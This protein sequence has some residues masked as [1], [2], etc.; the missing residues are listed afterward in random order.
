MLHLVHPHVRT[1]RTRP[2][3]FWR[4]ITRVFFG[5]LAFSVSVSHAVNCVSNFVPSNPDSAYQVDV[6]TGV[7]TDSRTG[8]MWKRAEESTF[9]NWP[10][11]LATAEAS[12]YAGY[13]DW[14]LPNIKELRS[15]V[16]ECRVQ[17]AIN[18]TIFP[19]GST[20]GV[21]SASPNIDQPNRAW[22]VDIRY[23]VDVSGLRD[24]QAYAV[25]LVRGGGAGFFDVTSPVLSAVSA[26]LTALTATSNEAATGY[27]I[28]VARGATAPTAAQ[29]KARVTYAG[30][31]I[32][33][34]GSGAMGAN[35][36]SSFPVAALSVNTLYDFY[37]VADDAAGNISLVAKAQNLVSA[38]CAASTVA[39]VEFM[40]LSAS[41]TVAAAANLGI[42]AIRTTFNVTCANG[43]FGVVRLPK[44]VLGVM[45]GDAY[46]LVQSSC[47]A[48]PVQQ[49]ANPAA[50]AS[51]VQAALGKKTNQAQLL[52]DALVGPLARWVCE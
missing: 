51:T 42:G 16:E 28:V 24:Q 47:A 27:W 41:M 34:S 44:V 32:V 18:D 6:A 3:C 33:A 38:E 20:F 50:T 19:G 5:A 40:D 10:T 1:H 49:M 43:R 29:V 13:S 35:S 12:V 8:L 31:T 30:V 39:T 48:K 37:L 9:M 45:T 21:W 7:V 11:A 25:R 23:G 52:A 36:A 26:T 15:V 22:A 4:A 46:A 14:R 2:S 17:P